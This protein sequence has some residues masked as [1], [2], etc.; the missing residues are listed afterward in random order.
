MSFRDRKA[1]ALV[2]A[3]V[4]VA[5]CFMFLLPESTDAENMSVETVVIESDMD[6]RVPI[7]MVI[8]QYGAISAEKEHQESMGKDVIIRDN[9]SKRGD[10]KEQQFVDDM[11][12]MIG[13]DK[14][15]DSQNHDMDCREGN[16]FFCNYKDEA[17]AIDM[18]DQRAAYCRSQPIGQT[19]V[20]S[21]I[22][23]MPVEEMGDT[24]EDKSSV[25]GRH[26]IV[27]VDEI[28]KVDEKFIDDAIELAKKNN[29]DLDIGHINTFVRDEISIVTSY[30]E[31]C[32]ICTQSKDDVEESEDMDFIII[33]DDDLE[34]IPVPDEPEVIQGLICMPAATVTLTDTLCGTADI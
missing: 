11:R 13:A 16:H 32:S 6:D 15:S 5:T 31:I 9:V 22:R 17:S 4:L 8:L 18:H 7:S 1:Y 12:H 29:L 26:E 27:V 2:M 19:E 33:E 25:E 10:P 20:R 28:T 34:C 14:R 24:A 30:S 23:G 3:A 21:N